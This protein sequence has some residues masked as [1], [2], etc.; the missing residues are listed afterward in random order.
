MGSFYWLISML[1][2][3][4]FDDYLPNGRLCSYMYYNTSVQLVAWG[5][6]QGYT[7]NMFTELIT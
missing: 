3:A 1:L 7:V 4:D 5:C 2:L 6:R